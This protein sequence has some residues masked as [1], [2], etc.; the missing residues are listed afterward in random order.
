MTP[1]EL[2]NYVPDPSNNINNEISSSIAAGLKKEDIVTKIVPMLKEIR[3]DFT[4]SR[5]VH[6]AD[7]MVAAVYDSV[8]KSTA[9]AAPDG[10]S[11]RIT[12]ED[13]KRQYPD[14]RSLQLAC[15][16][17]GVRGSQTQEKLLEALFKALQNEG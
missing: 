7:S 13:L 1:V 5:A 3:S 8:A 15:M 14:F 17:R 10:A 6:I 16:D 9:T 12:K 4:Q 2:N 11:N